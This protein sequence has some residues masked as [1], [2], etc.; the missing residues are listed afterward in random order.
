MSRK[1]NIRNA[2][3]ND[4]ATITNLNVQ[5]GYSASCSQVQEWLSDILASSNHCILVAENGETVVGWLVIEKR[6]SLET[7][8]KAEI[9]GLVVSENF[10]RF[11]IAR[12]LVETAG[13]WAVSKHLSRIVVRSNITRLESHHFYLKQDFIFVK[14]S[15]QYEK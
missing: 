11:G 5:L 15:H 3:I 13:H 4:V 10:R 1:V 14:T 6:L 7:G 12:L 8:Y 2:T 9:T